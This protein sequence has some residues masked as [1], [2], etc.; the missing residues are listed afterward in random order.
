MNNGGRMGGSI[1]LDIANNCMGL[2]SIERT[3]LLPQ[4]GRWLI[5][6]QK[7]HQDEIRNYLMKH[8]FPYLEETG[9]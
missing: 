9:Q 3:T 8:V 2:E 7:Q 4:R 1:E 6:V 5:V